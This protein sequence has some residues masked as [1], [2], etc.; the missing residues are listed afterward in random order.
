L[1]IY[2][3]KGGGRQGERVGREEQKV[4]AGRGSYFCKYYSSFMTVTSFNCL[5]T[6]PLDAREWQN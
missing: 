6:K 1:A 2:S 4:N 3:K 5:L